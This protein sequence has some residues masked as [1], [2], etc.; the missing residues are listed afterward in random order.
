MHALP[1]G[2][3]PQARGAGDLGPAKAESPALF[4]Y[5]G[6]VMVPLAALESHALNSLPS[7]MLYRLC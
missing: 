6:T 7:I 3:P 4:V 5:L 2:E 1:E